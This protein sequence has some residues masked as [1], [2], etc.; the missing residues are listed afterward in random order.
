MSATVM[1]RGMKKEWFDDYF[2]DMDVYFGGGPQA[3]PKKRHQLCW[4]LPEKSGFSD[5]AY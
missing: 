2:V 4:L 1:V 5:H 3:A